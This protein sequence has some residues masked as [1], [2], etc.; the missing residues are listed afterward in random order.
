MLVVVEHECGV[1]EE[2]VYGGQVIVVVG[3]R[4]RASSRSSLVGRAGEIVRRSA[5]EGRL[6][7]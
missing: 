6:V 3:R 1:V 2:E 5:V 4:S 7:V